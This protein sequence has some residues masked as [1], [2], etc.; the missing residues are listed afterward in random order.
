LRDVFLCEFPKLERLELLLGEEHYGFDGGVEDLQPLL[1]GER[2]PSLKF[3]GLMNS[4]IADDIAAV[5]VN[6]PI[7]QRIEELDL[8]MGNIT[9]AGIH[10]L[11]QLPKNTGLR[12][13]NVSHH[14]A[15]PAS[16]EALRKSVSCE[17]IAE[18]PQEI[19][20]EW[21]PILHA[22]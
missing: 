5:V 7:V 6:S 18:D 20:D 17:V 11:M 19:E 13:L 12:R 4:N 1:S 14:Y 9:D 22:E 16:I 10:S 21:R 3:L 2:F 8:S 15:S